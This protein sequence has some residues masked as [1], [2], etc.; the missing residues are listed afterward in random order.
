M[1]WEILPVE[2]VKTSADVAQI[3]KEEALHVLRYNTRDEAELRDRA[4]RTLEALRHQ[5]IAP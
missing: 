1:I 2:H 3:R 4:E 5:E